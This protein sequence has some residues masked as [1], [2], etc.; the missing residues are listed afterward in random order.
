MASSN[1]MRCRGYAARKRISYSIYRF[2]LKD[3]EWI[4][5]LTA[6][7]AMLF[8]CYAGKMFYWQYYPY[9]KSGDTGVLFYIGAVLLF[10]TG[11]IPVIERPERM[12]KRYVR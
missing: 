10:V 12:K 1:S 6:I 3:L 7:Y 2:S 9:I 5:V 11:I 4:I 8:V